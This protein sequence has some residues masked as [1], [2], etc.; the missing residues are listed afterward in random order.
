MIL[1]YGDWELKAC[2][3]VNRS[4]GKSSPFVGREGEGDD[5]SEWM[6]W[7]QE[8]KRWMNE[9]GGFIVQKITWVNTGISI[10]INLLDAG[11]GKYR[12]ELVV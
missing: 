10:E 7:G 9:P 1:A 6:S 3:V 12:S 8:V 4:Y 2:D 5:D 11:S